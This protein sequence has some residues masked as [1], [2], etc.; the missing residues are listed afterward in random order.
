MQQRCKFSAA[1]LERLEA[2]FRKHAAAVKRF[3]DADCSDV[4]RMW[5]DGTNERGQLLTAFERE[6]LIERH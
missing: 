3:R 2:H 1:D 6:A 4:I 5:R